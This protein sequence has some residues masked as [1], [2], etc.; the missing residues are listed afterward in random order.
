VNNADKLQIEQ[1]K[2]LLRMVVSDEYHE[3]FCRRGL[4]VQTKS[5]K[6]EHLQLSPAQIKIAA[7]AASQTKKGMP[8]RLRVLKSRQVHAS[9]GCASLIFR[10]VAFLPGQNAMVYGHLF[11]SASS[12]YRYY[13]LFATEYRP[14]DGLVCSPVE[15]RVQDHL[16]AFVGGSKIAF[17]SAQNAKGG[18]ASS[19]K[20]LHLSETAFWRDSDGLRTGLLQSV[21]DLLDTT[22]ID[23]ST[24]N[25]VGTPFHR[26]WQNAVEDGSG[27]E[28]G[29]SA[30]WMP[31][32]FGWHEHPENNIALTGEQIEG[33][34]KRY[35]DT[36]HALIAAYGLKPGQVAWRRW[37]IANAC[38]GDE[39]KFQQEQPANAEEA[40][41]TSGRSFYDMQVLGRH[42]AK[43]AM[44]RGDLEEVLMGTRRVV[45]F[46][47]RDDGN[48]LLR[49]YE[50]P[51]P[52]E[53]Y[54]IGVDT[55][56][57]IDVTDGKSATADP[58]FSVAQVLHARSGKQ[59]AMLR[60][61][62]EP[63]FFGQYLYDLMKYYNWAYMVPDADGPGLATIEEL[64]RQNVPVE[65]LYLNRGQANDLSPVTLQ[66]I[67]F[68]TTANSRPPVL[69]AL[70]RELREFSTVV[71]DATTLQELR[72]FVTFPDGKP[73]AAKA[74]HDDCVMALALAVLGKAK[75]IQ[76]E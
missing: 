13:D 1:R 16:I 18:R 21:P 65:R 4:S 56:K 75:A 3:E 58:D 48:G 15:R 50:M 14:I 19:I 63:S 24:A 54:V 7:A 38:E 33:L 10:R 60:G 45:Q 47:P 39:R 46:V 67:G 43:P 57:G 72:T 66:E 42:P 74:C 64:L 25:G 52:T 49:I 59:V 28:Y 27:D 34:Q 35:T 20:H 2:A 68:V 76:I 61:R 70:G 11:E 6:I 22:I 26:A 30:G 73:R 32:F 40:F 9:V 62:I 8:V 69:T 23:E 5:G 51:R 31:V 71:R 44:Q 41:L 17:G 37:K 36:E 12:L 29:D 53:A 55:A